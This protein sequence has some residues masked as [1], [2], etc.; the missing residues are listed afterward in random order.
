LQASLPLSCFFFTSS[1]RIKHIFVTPTSLVVVVSLSSHPPFL[2]FSLNSLSLRRSHSR[3]QASCSKFSALMSLS[4]QAHCS[5]FPKPSGLC[6]SSFLAA[7]RTRSLV[8]FA[9][10]PGFGDLSQIDRGRPRILF[11]LV[12]FR[13][14]SLPTSLFSFHV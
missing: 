6:N 2:V 10:R 12:L 1:Q 8:V 5:F 4:L 13:F 11:F 14:H 3:D 9:R 7:S